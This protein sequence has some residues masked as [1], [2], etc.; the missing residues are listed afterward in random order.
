MLVFT[1][2]LVDVASTLYC[3]A[4]AL[5]PHDSQNAKIS[6]MGSAQLSQVNPNASDKSHL[7]NIL[8]AGHDHRV[9]R[10]LSARLPAIRNR[11]PVN[12]AVFVRTAVGRRDHPA[13]GYAGRGGPCAW[14]G[15]AEV[16]VNWTRGRVDDMG[17]GGA[18]VRCVQDVV[19]KR[20]AVLYSIA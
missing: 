5:L 3:S 2:V 11:A 10:P 4:L 1:E 6:V 18:G 12:G 14:V 13:D 9:E 8:Y 15:C 7:I 16:R 20:K 17:R 19:N